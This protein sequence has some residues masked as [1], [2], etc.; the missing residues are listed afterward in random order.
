VTRNT[1]LTFKGTAEAGSTVKLFVDG[2]Q[3]ASGVATGGVYSIT[4]SAVAAGTRSVTATATDAAGNISAASAALSVTVDTTNAGVTAN[5]AGGT[6][7][8]AVTVTLSGEAGAP[9]Y[10][11]TNGT[12]PTTA[13]TRYTA[14]LT[15][16]ATTT[17]K[18]ISVD[19]AGNQSAVMSQTYTI[20]GTAPAAPSGLTLTAPQQGSVTLNWVD[21]SSNET[22]FVVERSLSQTTGFA[23]IGTVGANVRT[24]NDNTVA[25]RTTYFYR[26][27]AVNGVG[28]SAYSNVPS[29]R[30][31]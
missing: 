26:V 8:S 31:L 17:L 5:P 11:T 25:R 12:T 23:Q 3:R 22:S 19:L 13:S 24:F 28:S 15:I 27:K 20:G 4:V 10:Y 18:A 1:T 2:T 16:S 6:Y 9:I 14:A 30:S 7:A 29:I 21:N